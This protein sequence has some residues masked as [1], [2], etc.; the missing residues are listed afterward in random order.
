M[1]TVSVLALLQ[2]VAAISALS[3][4]G[5][6]LDKLLAKAGSER[7]SEKAFWIGSLL[8]GF[9]GVIVGGLLFHHKTSKGEFWVPVGAAVLLWLIAL[10]GY[11]MGY[12][13]W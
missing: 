11:W 1:V 8:G 9:P 7:V 12:L 13:R 3:F 6:G 2:W 4:F 5:M 10:V